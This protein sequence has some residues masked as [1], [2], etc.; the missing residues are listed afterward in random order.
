MLNLQNYI[1]SAGHSIESWTLDFRR[2]ASAKLRYQMDRR[3][4]RNRSGSSK[5]HTIYSIESCERETSKTMVRKHATPPPKK[6]QEPQME[7]VLLFI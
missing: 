7:Y 1:H 5:T 2:R 6:G 4:R 3:I